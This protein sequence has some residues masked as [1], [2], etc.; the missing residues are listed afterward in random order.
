MLTTDCVVVVDA[1]VEDTGAAGV[2][3]AVGAAG[4]TSSVVSALATSG[5]TDKSVGL[6]DAAV[7]V[8]AAVAALPNP[9]ENPE[10]VV[11]VA[12]A[13]TGLIDPNSVE[14]VVALPTELS[15]VVVFAAVEVAEL[16]NET[17][18]KRP[19]EV[20]VVVGAG[21]ML[22]KRPVPGAM[23]A[24]EEVPK[25]DDAVVVFVTEPNRV[26]ALV[27]S[28]LVGSTFCSRFV[29]AGNADLGGSLSAGAAGSAGLSAGFA[30]S[31]SF[32]LVRL[33]AGVGVGTPKET[34][35]LEPKE[36][37]GLAAVPPLLLLDPNARTAG[38]AGSAGVDSLGMGWMVR[39][40]ENPYAGG[41]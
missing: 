38:L 28:G 19:P 3:V 36:K 31:F 18:A 9:N 34:G 32:S 1:G 37:A 6:A 12:V 30:G 26:G 4:F 15:T 25:I 24:V 16:P 13:D 11:V 33:R 2:V 17:P 10:L 21:L 23:V 22:P 41:G 8:V 7:V 20:E 5:L 39:L 29:S 40:E 27:A 35:S 14:V